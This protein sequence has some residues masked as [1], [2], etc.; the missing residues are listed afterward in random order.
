MK[1]FRLLLIPLAAGFLHPQAVAAPATKESKQVPVVRVNATNQP[2]DFVHPWSKRAPLTRKALG[3]VLPGKRVLVTAELVANSNYVELERAESGAKM[4]ATVELVDYEANLAL[5]KPGDVQFLDGIKPVELAETA[6]GD[7]VSIWQLENTGALMT[8]GAVVTTVEVSRYPIDDTVLLT[9]RIS[10]PLQYR[11]GSFTVPLVKDGKLA[12]LVMRYDP[13]TQSG[14]VIPAPV[15]AHFL[16]DAATGHYGG[17]PRTGLGFAPMRDPQFR[18]YA[19]LND[20]PGGGVY[21]MS[22][23]KES[24]AE[25]ADLRVGDVIL[26]LNGQEI[27]QDG[28]YV[29]PHYGKISLSNLIATGGY[30]G[31][32]AKFHIFRGGKT[33]D[34]DV[35]LAHRPVEDSVIE[36]FIIDRAPRFYVLGGLVFQELSRQYLKEWG[37]E[38]Q[39]K[40]PERFV[41]FDR[42]QS[43]LF[44]DDRK[45]IV[46]LS[47]VLPSENTVGY[48]ELNNLVVTK[49]NNVTL[50]S[51]ADLEKAVASPV[52]GFHKIEF[53]EGPRVIYL[54]AKKVADESPA[55]MQNY[56]LRILKRT[57]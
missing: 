35:T 43:E 49:V 54:D 56:G 38:W 42:Y 1:N 14:D 5:L 23:Q 53:S 21:I 50:N 30:S 15:I 37:S 13:R 29:D 22:V 24:P 45:K 27:D 9:Y 10:T 52:D 7:H 31:E 11:E 33:F 18:H 47:Q 48:E 34:V 51:F 57:E 41:Y 55:L 36:P 26:A 8:T 4:A 20:N 25:K 46:I 28:N 12:G 16:K 39:K 6:V 2:W 17:F 44:Q 3:V 40:A 32:H 19:G